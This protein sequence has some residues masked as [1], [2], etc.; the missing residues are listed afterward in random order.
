M[1]SCFPVF[2]DL[3]CLHLLKAVRRPGLREID[4]RRALLRHVHLPAPLNRHYAVEARCI[5][6]CRTICRVPSPVKCSIVVGAGNSTSMSDGVRVGREARNDPGLLPTRRRCR[7]DGRSP[8]TVKTPGGR[9]RVSS[10]NVADLYGRRRL[11]R[12]CLLAVSVPIALPDIL[13]RR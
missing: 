6:V 9:L 3:P 4:S 5:W 2:P 1:A 10:C 13:Q 8:E 7:T 12:F 11:R